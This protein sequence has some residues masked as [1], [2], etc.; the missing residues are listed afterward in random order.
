MKITKVSAVILYFKIAAMEIMTFI[1]SA[2][3]STRRIM[4]LVFTL[5]FSGSG[6]LFVINLAAL[7]EVVLTFKMDDVLKV[8][9]SKY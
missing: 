9:L 5:T 2:C 7:C 4:V 1:I 3:S 8:L 6:K